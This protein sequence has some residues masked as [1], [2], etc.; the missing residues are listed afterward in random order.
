MN[1]NMNGGP[2]R[3]RSRSSSSASVS[4]PSAFLRYYSSSNHSRYRPSVSRQ[5]S[6]HNPRNNHPLRQNEDDDSSNQRLLRL[7]VGGYP[8]DVVRTSLPLL[9]TMMTDR[10]L[11]SWWVLSRF[12]CF[13]H[14]LMTTLIDTYLL[15]IISALS[16]FKSD[17]SLVDSDGR[18]FLD[19]DGKK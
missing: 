19:R 11:S 12:Y 14:F 1:V 6:P 7:N 4:S 15:R 18:I 8:Y 10:W 3:K 9:E 5:S 13:N 16:L 17:D 2:P